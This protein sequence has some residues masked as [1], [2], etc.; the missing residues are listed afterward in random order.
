ML[1]GTAHYGPKVYVW[2]AYEPQKGARRWTGVSAV[3]LCVSSTLPH[4]VLAALL[5]IQFG[6]NWLVAMTAV[7]DDSSSTTGLVA[8]AVSLG[9][10][11]A[12]TV[13]VV[14][15]VLLRMR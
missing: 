4:L 15:G 14:F 7:R 12:L 1:D 13:V 2:S 8:K 11:T 5:S 6:Q 10:A 3:Y 9:Q